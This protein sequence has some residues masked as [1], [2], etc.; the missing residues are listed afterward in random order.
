M[1]RKTRLTV[2]SYCLLRQKVDAKRWI[3]GDVASKYK[4]AWMVK[5][6][7]PGHVQKVKSSLYQICKPCLMVA[8]DESPTKLR[9][10]CGCMDDAHSFARDWLESEVEI[11]D[12]SRR[13]KLNEWRADKVVPTWREVAE[14]YMLNV[15][16]LGK[17]NYQRNIDRLFAIIEEATGF[18]ADDQPVTVLTW[19]LFLDWVQ[20]RQAFHLCGASKRGGEQG[21][22][23]ARLRTEI[24]ELK[25][26]RVKTPA[27][28]DLRKKYK[29]LR[30]IDQSNARCAVLDELKAE[31]GR[32]VSER[33]RLLEAAKM[34]LLKLPSQRWAMLRAELKARRL[35]P[36]D[37]NTVCPGNTTIKSYLNA[38]RA[39]LGPTGRS[40][41]LRGLE[42]PPLTDFM[43]G[44]VKLPSPRGHQEIEAGAYARMY[45]AAARLKGENLKLWVVNQM[46]WRFGCR[47]C[48][49]PAARLGWIEHDKEGP[50]FV[51]KNRPEED[52]RL[53]ARERSIV[54]RLRIAPDLWAAMR[55]VATEGS[56]IGAA[57]MTAARNLVEREHNEWMRQFVPE[58]Q[59]GNYLLRHWVATHVQDRWGTKMASLFLGHATS[60]TLS[61]ERMTITEDR[62][63]DSAK[64]CPALTW[65]DLAPVVTS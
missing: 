37:K 42:L 33:A 26:L 44:K 20:L 53:K 22:E 8:E 12:S 23:E 65:E 19:E 51:L 24:K 5:L 1:K 34:R 47:P 50:M 45:E 28:V 30:G 56:L 39:V 49:V 6:T 61:G 16:L 46:L 40:E 54:R 4:P 36:I 13:A 29:S 59:H 10:K 57:S 62:Y 32:V 35:P 64:A 63:G 15:P 52:F 2:G 48:E 27:L 14:L 31:R 25:R 9:P 7:L 18:P 60:A 41:Y 11:W 21:T 58:G 38:A 43:T 17:D 55:E 3:D